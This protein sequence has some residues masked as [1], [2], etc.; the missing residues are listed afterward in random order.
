MTCH[1]AIGLEPEQHLSHSGAGEGVDETEKDK[2]DDC[3]D[4]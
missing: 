2:T 1:R 3:H 4:Q